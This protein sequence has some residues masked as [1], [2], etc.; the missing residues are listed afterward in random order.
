MNDLNEASDI[1]DYRYYRKLVGTQKE[2]AKMLG[3]N[4][5][6]L[7]FRENGRAEISVESG[8]AMRELAR[9]VGYMVDD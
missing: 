8:L 3:F 2:V 1:N 7:S 6:T 4:R 9:Q 5:K